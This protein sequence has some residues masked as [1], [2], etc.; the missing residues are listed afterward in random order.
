M[1]VDPSVC[2]SCG[3]CVSGFD[4]DKVCPVGAI[5]F[6]Q[7]KPPVIDGDLCVNCGLCC[8]LC[9]LGAIGL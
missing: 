6:T 2:V 8:D 4:G 9:A 3:M 7:G 1:T 5:T